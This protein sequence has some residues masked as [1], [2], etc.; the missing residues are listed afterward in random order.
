MSARHEKYRRLIEAAK[1]LPRVTTGVAHPC[2]ASSLSGA[3]DAAQIGPMK[4]ILVGPRAK[5]AAIASQC[6]LDIS[7]YELVD[8]PHSHAAAAK[9]VAIV[10]RWPVARTCSSSPTSRLATCS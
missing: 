3:V 10:R 6:T 5:I 4:P 9:A 8:A 1:A 7:P 2:D